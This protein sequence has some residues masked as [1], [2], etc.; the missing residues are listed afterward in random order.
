MPILLNQAKLSV[1]NENGEY[2]GINTITER[3]TAEQIEDINSA[4]DARIEEIQDI[5]DEIDTAA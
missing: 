3:T 5:K 4:A 2:I 1:K